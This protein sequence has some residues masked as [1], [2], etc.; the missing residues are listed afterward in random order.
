MIQLFLGKIRNPTCALH[1]DRRLAD[2]QE[3]SRKNSAYLESPSHEAL[4][5]E[6]DSWGAQTLPKP[7]VLGEHPDFNLQT[8]N[9][10]LPIML[11]KSIK[12]TGAICL[13]VGFDPTEFSSSLFKELVLSHVQESL[14]SATD[15]NVVVPAYNVHAMF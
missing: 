4:E 14:P 3:N 15:T 7:W 13:F 12:S 9:L 2:G 1:R 10:K 5:Q 6:F 11:D 8:C